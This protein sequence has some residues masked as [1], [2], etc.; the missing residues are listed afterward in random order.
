MRITRPSPAMVVS[1]IA[2]L[3]SLGV[4]ARAAN[5]IFSTDI[6]DGEVKTADLANLAVSFTKLRSNSVGSI[7]VINDSLTLVD[8]AGAD[9]TGLVSLSG[10]AN[11]RCS[12][13]TLG[14][15]GAKVGDIAVV[16]TNGAIQN[17]VFLYAMR[18]PSD[19]NVQASIC[20]FSGTTMTAITD[21]PVRVV[22]FR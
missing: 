13:V 6:V 21:L 5:T 11:G 16:A 3:V 8:L 20:N 18:V 7:K 14:V 9:V 19:A 4:G 15:S 1:C 12:Q 22:T 10:I 2:L 17:G